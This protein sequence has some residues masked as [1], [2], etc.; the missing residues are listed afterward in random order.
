MKLFN[1]T[2]HLFFYELLL[3]SCAFI[4]LLEWLLPLYKLT[5]IDRLLPVA[6]FSLFCF[7]LSFLRVQTIVGVALKGIASFY[8]I[9]ILYFQD[10]YAIFS[11]L[12]SFFEEMVFNIS[13]FI[14]GDWQDVTVL[15]RIVLI[16]LLIWL[17]SY[18]LHYWFVT[19][20]RVFFFFML[21]V[22]YVSIFHTFQ[23][24]DAGMS[25]V[26]LVIVGIIALSLANTL[27][28]VEREAVT[29]PKQKSMLDAYAAIIST[30]VITVVVGYF[31]PVKEP[32]WED[33]VPQLKQAAEKITGKDFSE[34]V[35]RKV[36]YGEDDSEL[37]GTFQQD[38]TTQFLVL[39]THGQYWRIETKD[40]YTGKG[41]HVSNEQKSSWQNGQETSFLDKEPLVNYTESEATF[42]YS[43]ESEIERII[44]PYWLTRIKTDDAMSVRPDHY[45]ETARIRKNK[46]FD[47]R[48]RY[49]TVYES[50]SYSVDGLQA[51][52]L[53]DV[54]AKSIG[55][56]TQLP[57]D[58]PD[59]VYDLAKEITKPYDNLYDQVVAVEQYFGANGFSYETVDIPIPDEDEDYVDQFLFETK[60][61]YCDNYSTS[62][63]VLLR[64]LGIDARW[65]KGF[66][67]GQLVDKEEIA[68]DTF[69]VYE[70]TSSNA[71]SWVEVYFPGSG[72]VPFE[73][74]QGFSNLADF[75][76]DPER[77]NAELPPK[78]EANE[79]QQEPEKKE[80]E[81][82]AKQEAEEK[83]KQQD[84]NAAE[85]LSK[86]KGK[87]I[88]LIVL[89]VIIVAVGVIVYLKRNQFMIR[90]LTKRLE[91]N[92]TEDTYERSFTFLLS[93]LR[94]ENLGK[95]KEET[96]RE[97]AIRI[98][99]T[100][101]MDAMRKWVRIYERYLYNNEPIDIHQDELKKLWKTIVDHIQ[102]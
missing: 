17:M 32:Q 97:Y 35:V 96:L 55:N 88:W 78:E 59:R 95:S 76:R 23:P 65:V 13:M 84:R 72:W 89:L 1:R 91:A 5:E 70:V 44:Y 46:D 79:Q 4:L 54:K 98:D 67:E 6:L 43:E 29:L 87:T 52:T 47:E 93:L 14:S 81:S 92:P 42:L 45:N 27:K 73:P 37:G 19:M 26:R 9:Y 36:G 90:H 12:P 71:H 51:I 39:A 48:I 63:V 7:S 16:A 61:G 8:L 41:W 28:M 86:N 38:D 101:K 57:D 83:S 77:R 62:M 25:I 15:F 58:V 21:T 33:P 66:T 68:G 50:P 60:K 20:K 74:T 99:E 102:A 69:N 2:K 75:H 22:V 64:T 56:Y 31:S 94:R 80:N 24:Y 18:L 34:N 100:Y 10:V 40:V 85:G 49:T 11:W 53:D 30:I 82:E 3:Y